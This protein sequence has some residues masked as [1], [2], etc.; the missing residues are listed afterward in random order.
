MDEMFSIIGRFGFN[1]LSLQLFL[2]LNTN[3]EGE[4]SLK[5]GKLRKQLAILLTLAICTSAMDI[6]AFAEEM[7]GLEQ[8]YNLFMREKIIK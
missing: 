4:R 8:Q 7:N 3:K 6:S 2:L 1:D 5:K